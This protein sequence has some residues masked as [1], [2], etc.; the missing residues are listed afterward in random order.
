MEKVFS[1]KFDLN[2]LY[3]TRLVDRLNVEEILYFFFFKCLTHILI[4]SGSE[5]IAEKVCSVAS[6]PR[7]V[8]LQG[9]L[10]IEFKM[11]SDIC[12]FHCFQLF[13]VFNTC[14]IVWFKK[15]IFLFYVIRFVE[16]VHIK[17]KLQIFSIYL[18]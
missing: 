7:M 8:F 15:W 10:G 3:L 5:Y 17:I 6:Q 11:L 16:N 12:T 2:W 1:I 14:V 18:A 4:H 9:A 13:I